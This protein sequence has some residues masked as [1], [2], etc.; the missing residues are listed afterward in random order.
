M[1]NQDNES[2]AQ[3]SREDEIHADITD[4][5]KKNLK[6]VDGVKTGDDKQDRYYDKPFDEQMYSTF[7][8]LRE[9][10]GEPE[11]GEEKA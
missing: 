4:K 5:N 11:S 2:K 7:D 3:K 9:Q 6:M 8:E 1:N 10:R